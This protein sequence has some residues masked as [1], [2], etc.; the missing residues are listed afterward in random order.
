MIVFWEFD[1]LLDILPASSESSQA[2]APLLQVGNMPVEETRS[3]RGPMLGLQH[4]IAAATKKSESAWRRFW[5]GGQA[6]KPAWIAPSAALTVGNLHFEH[7]N[8]TCKPPSGEAYSTG[9]NFA[10]EI[11]RWIGFSG[12]NVNC[13][14]NLV[15]LMSGITD[16]DRGRILLCE[17]DISTIPLRELRSYVV[18]VPRDPFLFC[19]TIRDNLDLAGNARGDWQIWAALEQCHAGEIVREYDDR[20]DHFLAAGGGDLPPSTRRLL[21]LARAVLA[22]E[23]N[24]ARVLCLEDYTGSFDERSRDLILARHLGGGM[25]VI[26]TSEDTLDPEIFDSVIHFGREENDDDL[27]NFS[28]DQEGNPLDHLS[29][30]EVEQGWG[31]ILLDIPSSISSSAVGAVG[32]TVG[33]VG[34][35]VGA[36]GSGV[37]TTSKGIVKVFTKKMKSVGKAAGS[38]MPKGKKDLTQG[39][40]GSDCAPLVQ[41]SQ[42]LPVPQPAAERGYSTSEEE[43]GAAASAPGGRSRSSSAAGSPSVNSNLMSSSPAARGLLTRFGGIGAAASPPRPTRPPPPPPLT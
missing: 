31:D 38:L 11:G 13:T 2:L 12:L 4:E 41:P 36:V 6:P 1:D 10:V 40:S 19:G 8:V 30:S 21:V 22:A 9:L 20:L 17:K 26:V 39:I 33:A 7:V 23:I 3:G 34:S 32:K 37:G 15:H 28:Q 16:I 42:E 18:V 27:M 14:P 24:G 29:D 35:T 43:A 5:A 25:V